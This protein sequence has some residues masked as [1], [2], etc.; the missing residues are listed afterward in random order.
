MHAI[1][2]RK[3]G[4]LVAVALAAA[5]GGE[6]PGAGVAGQREATSVAAADVARASAARPPAGRGQSRGVAVFTPRIV[7]ERN[8]AP[9][10]RK[11]VLSPVYSIDRLY[12]S[13]R[14][15]QSSVAFRLAADKLAPEPELL[16]V[17]AFEAV[18]VAPDGV[19]VLSDEFMCHSNLNVERDLYH[20][21]VL[22]DLELTAG[23]LFTLAQGQLSA[24]LPDGYGL[25]VV[26]S[27][28]VTLATQVLNHNVTDRKLDVRH[29]IRIE[30][31]RDR[32]LVRPL[33]PLVH[34]GVVGLKLIDGPDGYVQ[35]PPDRV[36]PSVHGEGCGI[37]EPAVDG[38]SHQLED[39]FGRRFTSFW[40][41]KPGREVNHTRVTPMLALPYD[42]T[43]HY[44]TAHLHP[45]AESLELRDLSTGETVFK[46]R[47]RQADGRIGLA[48]VEHYASPEGIPLYRDHEYELISIYENSSGRDQDS[49]ATMMLYL[50]V[51][52]FQLKAGVLAPMARAA[53]H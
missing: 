43:A 45:F 23:R 28:R 29:R 51:Q 21:N 40:L 48:E 2:R 35:I 27:Q 38:K 46:S 26:S 12:G 16:W 22:S 49:M 7:G 13:M 17:T 52:D 4:F 8:G 14:G 47:T 20:E 31:V 34:H 9:L 24:R 33:V 11:E 32:D 41:V 10:Y 39:G 37:G 19:T 42:T 50:R 25:P 53:S 6:P 1:A 36:D 44:I 3:S 30:F 5:C 15:P 18:M